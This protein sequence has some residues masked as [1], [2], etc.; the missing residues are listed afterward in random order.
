M[1]DC[2]ILELIHRIDDFSAECERREH[3]DTGEAWDLLHEIR[4]ELDAARRCDAGSKPVRVVAHIRGSAVSDVEL[5]VGVILE[6]RDYDVDGVEDE[7]MHRDAA[8]RRHTRQLWGD[9]AAELTEG[10]ES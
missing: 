2:T 6:V 8:G 4:E 1:T 10:S 7:C 9:T 5:P 3:T